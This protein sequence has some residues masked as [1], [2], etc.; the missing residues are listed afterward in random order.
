MRPSVSRESC[1]GFD[2][3]TFLAPPLAGVPIH[4]RQHHFLPSTTMN[5]LLNNPIIAFS[6]VFICFAALG[7]TL[8]V[9]KPIPSMYLTL[10][11][12]AVAVFGVLA[13]C[14]LAINLQK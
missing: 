9:Q 7:Y 10:P 3:K 5:N 8:A 14:A 2:V 6:V 12:S 1:G 13:G 4:E 11:A